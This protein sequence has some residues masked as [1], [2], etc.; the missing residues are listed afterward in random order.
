[1]ANLD[2]YALGDDLR[3]LITFLYAETDAVIFELSSE[4]DREPRQFRSLSE[5]EEVFNLG[6]YRAG[7]LQIWSPLVMKQ[8]VFER[9]TL[10]SVPGHSFRYSVRG[11]GLMQLYLDGVRD[12][13][14]YHT[15]YGHWNEAGA[16]RASMYPAGDCDWPSLTK[17]SGR[18]QRYIRG[19]LADAK[20]YAR[21]VLH[22]AF[23]AV[24]NGDGLWWGP[25]I[26]RADSDE[27]R[28]IR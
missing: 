2:F 8:P 14:I 3:N 24:Q 26:K 15:H 25:D 19:K 23:Q 1:M 4:F 18:I 13:V 22:Y 21:P 5:L 11:A 12:G 9:V 27:I 16:R 10:R 17:L 6:A 28:P 7:H 20:L